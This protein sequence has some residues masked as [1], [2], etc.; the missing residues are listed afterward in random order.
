M[1]QKIDEKL[2]KILNTTKKFRLTLKTMGIGCL[3]QPLIV[4]MR[5]TGSNQYLI[6]ESFGLLFESGNLNIILTDLKVRFGFK[7]MTGASCQ[8]NPQTLTGQSDSFGAK[9]QDL[10][11]SWQCF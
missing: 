9:G 5:T 8:L 4:C 1:K 10:E 6:K 7:S 2:L 11:Q 3:L